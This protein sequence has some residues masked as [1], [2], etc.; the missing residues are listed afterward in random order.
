MHQLNIGIPI[1][2][3][4]VCENKRE[5]DDAKHYGLPYIIR[6]KGYTDEMLVACVMYRT[7]VKKFPHINWNKFFGRNMGESTIIIKVPGDK[8]AKAHRESSGDSNVAD[9]ATDERVFSSGLEDECDYAERKL[10]E[11]IGDMSS[12][13]NIEQ[14]QKLI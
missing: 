5:A 2:T 9:I 3:V 11:Y 8:D 7:L 13:V 1:P 14:L 10:D 12:K 4:Y 6:P